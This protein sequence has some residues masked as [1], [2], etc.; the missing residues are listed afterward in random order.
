MIRSFDQQSE[1]RNPQSEIRNPK[2][3][4]GNPQSS[5]VNRQSALALVIAAVALLNL[6]C[7][8]KQRTYIS[9][10]T[11]GTGGVYYS[12]GGGLANLWSQHVPGVRAVAE[13]T[14][15]SVENVKLAHK[16]DTVIGEI[17]SD[18]AYQAYHGQGQ[19]ENTPQD[20]LGLAVMYPNV[21]QVVTLKGSGVDSLER[22][23]GHTVSIGSPGSGTAF[24]SELVL[25]ALGTS[26]DSLNVRRLSFVENA[27]A[28]RDHSID[29]GVWCVA[30]PTSSIMDLATTHGIRV[31]PFTLDEQKKVTERYTFYS[32]YDLPADV[33]RGVD[34]PVPTLSV[35]NVIICQA[36]LPEDLVYKLTK[37]L[38]EHNDDMRT[39]H[40]FARFTTPEN[41]VER[42]PIPLHPGTI[43]YLKEI[44]LTIPDGL[45]PKGT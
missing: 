34:S 45:V 32:A 42:A 8:D 23:K 20:I 19:F 22:L 7:S 27:N 18:V 9:I 30:P 21:Y 16:G 10:G 38:F 14:G 33:Y 4:I 41:T 24:M 44:G 40:P 5:I 6:S 29:V 15:G 11:G 12:Y 28:L 43:K 31:I 35:W 39:I 36:D 1:I 13:V 37:V 2:S 26:Q 17:M 3:A 25:E